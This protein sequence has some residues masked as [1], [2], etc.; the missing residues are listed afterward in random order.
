MSDDITDDVEEET[1]PSGKITLDQYVGFVLNNHLKFNSAEDKPRYGIFYRGKLIKT[2][3]G[4]FA[5]SSVGAAKLALYNCFYTAER[6]YVDRRYQYNYLGIDCLNIEGTGC[7]RE[8]K[9]RF[10]ELLLK[11][12]EIKTI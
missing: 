6:R 11:H 4:K 10:R 3:S 9:N 1:I 7:A 2:N 8:D 5:F 12:V